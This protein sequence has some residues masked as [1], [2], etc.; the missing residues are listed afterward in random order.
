M[1]YFFLCQVVKQVEGGE[2]IVH[3]KFVTSS[4]YF[5][6]KLCHCRMCSCQ[7]LCLTLFV[8]P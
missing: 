7:V 1:R 2:E 3:V 6:G 4:L 8:L 5:P